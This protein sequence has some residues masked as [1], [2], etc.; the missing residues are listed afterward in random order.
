[1]K[2]A[3]PRL[4]A[5]EVKLKRRIDH[6]LH[7]EGFVW[8]LQLVFMLHRLRRELRARFEVPHAMFLTQEFASGLHSEK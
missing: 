8:T 6:F 5:E 2:D 4:C 1:M 7:S 3:G